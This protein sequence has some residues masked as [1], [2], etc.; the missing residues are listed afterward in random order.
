MVRHEI[1]DRIRSLRNE[2]S[3]S[4]E[5]LADHAGV[6]VR[7]IQRLEKDGQ[8]SHETLLAVA[9]AF[10]IDVR[11]LTR[12]LK[13]DRVVL[14]EA[15]L[16]RS[17]GIE[18]SMPG[19]LI[20]W[21][22]KFPAINKRFYKNMATAGL[23][24]LIIPLLFIAVS[25]LKYSF[26]FS[27][28]A[29]P[30][31]WLKS[32][33]FLHQLV[34]SPVFLFS[35]LLIALGLNV[36]PLINLNVKKEPEELIGSFSIKGNRWNAMIAGASLFFM[37][38][39]MG[40]AAVDGVSEAST[41]RVEQIAQELNESSSVIE[42]S[43][44]VTDLRKESRLATLEERLD[45]QQAYLDQV[46]AYSQALERAKQ[47]QQQASRMGSQQHASA[48]K[49]Q[50]K[51]YS[52]AMS[53]AFTRVYPE[54]QIFREVSDPNYKPNFDYSTYF[55]SMSSELES[56]LILDENIHEVLTFYDELITGD[57]QDD[58]LENADEFVNTAWEPM[59]RRQAVNLT[60]SFLQEKILKSSSEIRKLIDWLKTDP[61]YDTAPAQF[62]KQLET[63]VELR[64]SNTALLNQLIEVIS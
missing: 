47:I 62:F 35:S 27:G 15:P 34:T 45:R 61:N 7:T 12:L 10:D 23:A 64:K 42:N 53:T 6:S 49:S 16:S 28:F 60:Y 48:F 46:K 57:Y 30:F 19:S 43:Q 33:P 37:T 32:V 51:G 8:C 41:T 5:L 54:L 63:I 21:A 36:L 29:N 9:A 58:F 13:Q 40:Y 4:Q 38:F 50:L 18:F 44:G 20:K 39:M 26:G 14:Q 17:I 1:A 22:N 56:H 52:V 24:F 55:A 3:W 31:D 2:H 25:L 59:T 11:Q